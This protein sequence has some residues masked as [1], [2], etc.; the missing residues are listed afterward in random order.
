MQ[1]FQKMNKLALLEAL[2]KALSSENDIRYNST[3]K[4]SRLSR[5]IK[6]DL[7][8]ITSGEEYEMLLSHLI[9]L[10]L[11]TPSQHLH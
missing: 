2:H 5:Q 9:L 7:L 10:A 6:E 4:E 11:P 3:Q 1:G 8:N